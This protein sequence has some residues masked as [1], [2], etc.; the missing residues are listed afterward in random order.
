[1]PCLAPPSRAE[2]QA[3]MFQSVLRPVLDAENFCFGAP[4][5]ALSLGSAAQVLLVINAPENGVPTD[6][7]DGDCSSLQRRQDDWI[8]GKILGLEGVHAGEPDDAAPCKIE[9]E[10]I[11]ADIDGAKIPIFVDE[12]VNHVDGVKSRGEKDRLGDVAMKLVLVCNERQI[13][14]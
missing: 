2:K 1:M 10:M 3:I 13:T 11:V 4:Y 8:S 9:S 6:T 12:E 5:L 7:S 14:T